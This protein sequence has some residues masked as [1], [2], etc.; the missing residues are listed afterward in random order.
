MI[1]VTDTT[2]ATIV[3][4]LPNVLITVLVVY[5]CPFPLLILRLWSI[6]V[7]ITWDNMLLLCWGLERDRRRLKEY[8]YTLNKLENPG[9][10]G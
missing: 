5:T 9:G 10:G 3:L 6:S 4:C 1:I 8:M 2:L 7:E